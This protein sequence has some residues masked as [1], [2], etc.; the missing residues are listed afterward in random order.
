[1][2]FRSP[3]VKH[4]LSR[5][6]ISNKTMLKNYGWGFAVRENHWNLM[7]FAC[8]QHIYHE[9]IAFDWVLSDN[10]KIVLRETKR[11]WSC[12]ARASSVYAIKNALHDHPNPFI[13]RWKLFQ[14]PHVDLLLAQWFRWFHITKYSHCHSWRITYSFAENYADRHGS[15]G[16]LGVYQSIRCISWI[17]FLCIS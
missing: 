11:K 3:Y 10:G 17:Q 1:M 5:S 12:P 13:I 15:H 4:P 16:F 8:K 6:F 2:D 14:V 9:T 7:H